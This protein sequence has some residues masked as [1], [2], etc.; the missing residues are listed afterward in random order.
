MMMGEVSCNWRV[1]AVWL[2]FVDW[3]GTSGSILRRGWALLVP[4]KALVREASREA[5]VL[6]NEPQPLSLRTFMPSNSMPLYW[7]CRLYEFSP[8]SIVKT[9]A[10]DA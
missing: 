8:I 2:G 5:M 1:W 4:V 3:G 9:T 6:W 10:L 7:K